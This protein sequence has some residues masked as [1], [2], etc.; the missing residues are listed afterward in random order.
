VSVHAEQPES[1]IDEHRFTINSQV[2]AKFDD[3][4]VGRRNGCM[5]GRCP[6]E[7]AGQ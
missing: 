3:A 7:P 1:V 2:S 5:P 4:A 6:G